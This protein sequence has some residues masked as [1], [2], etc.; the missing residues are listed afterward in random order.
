MARR[1]NGNKPVAQATGTDIP[2]ATAPAGA[3]DARQFQH[4]CRGASV[5]FRNPVARATGKFPFTLR[6]ANRSNQFRE[7]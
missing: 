2:Y 3:A 4:P 5:V 6:V 1:T 7:T